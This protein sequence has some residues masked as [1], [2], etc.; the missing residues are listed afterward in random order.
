MDW[1]RARFAGI[2]IIGKLDSIDRNLNLVERAQRK[3]A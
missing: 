3:A 1:A 2:C